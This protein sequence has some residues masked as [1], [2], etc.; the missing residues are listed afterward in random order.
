MASIASKWLSPNLQGCRVQL[1]MNEGSTIEG[2]VVDVSQRSS[3]VTL[4]QVTFVDTAVQHPLFEQLH[5]YAQE[6]SSCVVLQS[7]ACRKYEDEDRPHLLRVCPVPAH[8]EKRNSAH[9]NSELICHRQE[10]D[11]SEAIKKGI[12]KLI[13]TPDDLPNLRRPIATDFEVIDEVNDQLSEAIAA[14]RKEQTIF[15]AYEGVKV[16]RHGHLSV[17]AVVASSKVYVF[18][19][20]KMKKDL[21]GHG[22]K[23]IFESDGIEK[24]IHGCR[25]LSDCLHH[26]YQVGLNNVFD[27][28][29]ADVIIYINKKLESGDFQFPPYVRDVQ[30]CLRTFLNLTGDQLKYTRSRQKNEDQACTWGQRPLSLRQ[31]DALVKDVVYL[32]EL[33]H[34]CLEQMLQK[35]RAGVEFFLGLDRD[36]SEEEL[37]CLPPD[38]VL[39]MGFRDALK[40]SAMRAAPNNTCRS[41]DESCYRE[42]GH[43]ARRDNDKRNHH[44]YR[45]SLRHGR[46]FSSM[47]NDRVHSRQPRDSYR[48]EDCN[49]KQNDHY[50]VKKG[51]R[52]EDSLLYMAM[53]PQTNETSTELSDLAM[54]SAQK[55]NVG[56]SEKLNASSEPTESTQE[57]PASLALQDHCPVANGNKEDSKADREATD[58]PHSDTS[59]CSFERNGVD[60]FRQML[61]QHFNGNGPPCNIPSGNHDSGH[62]VEA[63]TA[64]HTSDNTVLALPE[65]LVEHC[66]GSGHRFDTMQ[67]KS[68]VQVSSQSS[69]P[70]HVERQ[71]GVLTESKPVPGWNHNCSPNTEPAVDKK[72]APKS[73]SSWANRPVNENKKGIS[74]RPVDMKVAKYP[75]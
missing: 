14:I 21:F 52:T 32:G 66:Y 7:P 22:L 48:Q 51:K 60:A 50:N 19:V 10:T 2:V 63:L 75:G 58:E 62:Q 20:Q 40:L 53:Q 29:V 68:L 61:P 67:H 71:E 55:S 11:S 12:I 30:S 74:F 9:N 59:F 42:H 1:Q 35:F 26:H 73:P 37:R 44:H 64:K 5:F 56:E 69:S 33:A 38:H 28:M 70:P 13:G 17:L 57:E 31:I 27:T 39:P 54:D 65:T 72:R 34:V 49:Q 16:G 46:G 45:D 23:E 24:I 36:C 18:D 8:L 41:Y 25:K 6:I 3:K 43:L 15:V 47:N 4:D